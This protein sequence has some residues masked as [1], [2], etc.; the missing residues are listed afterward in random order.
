M[1]SAEGPDG[2]CRLH[3][4]RCKSTTS[5]HLGPKKVEIGAAPLD[6]GVVRRHSEKR[7]RV[8]IVE[9][10]GENDFGGVGVPHDNAV[11]L[12]VLANVPG[13]PALKGSNNAIRP[14]DALLNKVRRIL[15]SARKESKANVAAA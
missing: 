12:L 1:V 3:G 13:S 14:G 7:S 8:Y 10:G 5:L 4:P 11:H 15:D 6:N 2:V 9:T